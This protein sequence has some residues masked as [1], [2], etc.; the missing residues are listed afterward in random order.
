MGK[1]RR[2]RNHLRSQACGK[3]LLTN[4]F[5]LRLIVS[6]PATSS[7]QCKSRPNNKRK[8]ANLI[9]NRCALLHRV[10]DARRGRFE[11]NGRH[12]PLEEIPVLRPLDCLELRPNELDAVPVE[13][14]A[15]G[16][17]DGEVKRGLAAHG[18][19]QGVGALGGDDLLQEVR[20]HGAHVGPVGEVWVGHDSGRVGVDEDYLVALVSEGLHRLGP[21]VVELARLTDHD[22]ASP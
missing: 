21:R 2:S 11:P 9:G 6:N 4:I 3:S 17:G 12:G 15:L 10:T 22:G 18:G 8:L 5:E 13:S 14:P 1:Q 16:E 20:G 7:S 19:K